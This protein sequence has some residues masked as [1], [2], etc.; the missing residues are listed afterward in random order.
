MASGGAQMTESLPAK[1]DPDRALIGEVAMDI[2][3]EVVSHLRIQYPGA[4][5]ALGP[6]GQLSLRN[7]VHNQIMAALDT[8][9]ADEI[10]VRL[11]RRKAERRKMHAAWDKIRSAP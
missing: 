7:C 4:F 9:D 11:E 1:P 2:G 3:K 6:S 8:T 10:R 5:A